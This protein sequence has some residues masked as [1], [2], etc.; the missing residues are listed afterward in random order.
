MHVPVPLPDWPIPMAPSVRG[1]MLSVARTGTEFQL[2]IDVGVDVPVKYQLEWRD[3]VR[4]CGGVEPVC[5][6]C[7][8]GYH[9][10]EYNLIMW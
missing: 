1:A 7:H 6:V 5:S 10:N 9:V 4:P 8:G 2:A 3:V